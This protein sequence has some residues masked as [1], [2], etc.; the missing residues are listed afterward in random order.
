MLAELTRLD[1]ILFFAPMF[2][3]AAVA[4][5]RRTGTI[6]GIRPFLIAATVVAVGLAAW[7]AWKL[8]YY[9]SILTNSYR[10]NKVQ[11]STRPVG[12]RYLGAFFRSHYFVTPLIGAALALATARR[13]QRMGETALLAL[14]VATWL[15]YVMYVGGDFMEFRLLV[16][17][18][19]LLLV[20]CFV[21]FPRAGSITRDGH[22]GSDPCPRRQRTSSPLLQ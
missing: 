12:F 20:L 21:G 16:P 7:F 5:A 6:S 2:G 9:G 15:T 4:R 11:S 3:M 13:D 22:G 17:V 19:P 18:I 10:A 14:P 1:S 8:G